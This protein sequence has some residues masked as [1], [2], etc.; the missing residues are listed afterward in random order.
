MLMGHYQSRT[1]VTNEAQRYCQRRVGLCCSSSLGCDF[2]R[3]HLRCCRLCLIL[4]ICRAGPLCPRAISQREPWPFCH[5]VSHLLSFIRVFF[6]Y[7][8]SK[9][10]IWRGLVC[11]DSSYSPRTSFYTNN[12]A[13]LNGKTYFHHT[14]LLFFK[15]T[16]CILKYG[17]WCHISVTASFRN[18]FTEES[19][20]W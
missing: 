19:T 13:S 8:Q 3:Y 16:C 1:H 4:S 2:C 12:R 18:A 6:P 15:Q 7:P 14:K 11:Y 20:L 17:G 9:H 5:W 10:I